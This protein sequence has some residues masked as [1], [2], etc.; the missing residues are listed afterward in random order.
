MLFYPERYFHACIKGELK[1]GELYCWFIIIIILLSKSVD[2]VQFFTGED[3]FWSLKSRS[4]KYRWLHKIR[5]GAPTALLRTLGP[6]KICHLRPLSKTFW[7]KIWL[8]LHN[9]QDLYS[10][11][12]KWR[13]ILASCLA[14]ILIVRCIL[15]VNLPWHVFPAVDSHWEGVNFAWAICFITAFPR[16]SQSI[17]KI[18]PGPEAG[19]RH[20]CCC[21]VGLVQLLTL[22]V[23]V[24]VMYRLVTPGLKLW[25]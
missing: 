4:S 9:I 1:L 7:T 23:M 12:C 11:K 14:Y 21:F 15:Q 13:H 24:M 19:L 6:S 20:A 8:Q 3:N 16:H 25:G 5:C 22:G 2:F 10:R 17:L 18:W